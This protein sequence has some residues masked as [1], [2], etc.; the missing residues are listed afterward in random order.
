MEHPEAERQK[1]QHRQ[2]E[3]EPGRHRTLLDQGFAELQDLV[4]DDQQEQ[5]ERQV[6]P[7]AALR[8]GRA[9]RYREEGEDQDRGD[10]HDARMELRRHLV[11]RRLLRRIALPLPE[12]DQRQLALV[13]AAL[14]KGRRREQRVDLARKIPDPDHYRLLVRRLVDKL[15]RPFEGEHQL[16]VLA[17]VERAPLGGG[18]GHGAGG[19]ALVKKHVRQP[20]PVLGDAADGHGHVL[21][22]GQKRAALQHIVP[23][24]IAREMHE[25]AVAVARMGLEHADHQ[26]AEQAEQAGEPEDRPRDA[27]ETDAAGIERVQL[28]VLAKPDDRH[29]DRDEEGGGEGEAQIMRDQIEHDPADRAERRVLGRDQI[30]ETDEA[31]HQER[32]HHE[33]EQHR[34]TREHVLDEISVNDG[35]EAETP[36]DTSPPAVRPK[37]AI[38]LL[39]VSPASRPADD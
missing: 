20:P 11:H 24:A 39:S 14:A 31:L 29:Q 27:E 37:A 35:H 38:D 32:E 22:A 30:Q 17:D 34:E 7:L 25:I 21:D 26:R 36:L 1:G 23:A 13:P 9:E 4:V 6:Q 18:R 33:A 8:R 16:L 2:L 12:L 15:G 19:V 10:A 28:A 3:P 5:T